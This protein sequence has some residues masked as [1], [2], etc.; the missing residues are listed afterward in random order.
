MISSPCKTCPKMNLPKDQCLGTC[1]MIRD[2][3]GMHL[4]HKDNSSCTS[5]DFSE[6]SCFQIISLLG[7]DC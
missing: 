4:V 7:H 2:I 6:E 3:Q 5:V 1:Q